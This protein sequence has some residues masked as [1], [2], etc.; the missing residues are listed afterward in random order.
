MRAIVGLVALVMLGTLSGAMIR[1]AAEEP[2]PGT[3]QVPDSLLTSEFPLKK[4]AQAVKTDRRLDVVVIGSRSATVM[5]PDGTS[6][7]A[8]MEAALRSKLPGVA[9][10]V[11]LQLQIKK[12]AEE[13]VQDL[14]HLLEGKTPQLVI[15]QTGTVDA[16]R[17]VDPDDFQVS[18][19]EGVAALQKR[20]VDV[21]LINLQ[22]G[23]R[24][25]T[26]ISTGP[27]LDVMRMVAQ[28]REIPLFDR[29]AIM[30]RWN[31]DGSFDLFSPSRGV[32]LARRVH[33]CLGR[34]LSRF[35]IEAAQIKPDE[36][37]TQR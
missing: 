5:L 22:Y 34:A 33:D 13:V 8:R 17:A 2:A 24:M 15:W 1:A 36:L 25:E 29:F 30:H 27:Y 3:C 37:G 21:V 4:V 32:E 31:D 19:D 6:F 28:H 10:T 20:G 16:L 35:I 26:M 12:T 14:D 7:P 9:V 23:P 11:S 18:V